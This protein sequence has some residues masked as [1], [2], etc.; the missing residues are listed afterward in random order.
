MGTSNLQFPLA[1]V[2]ATR[3]S[4][5]VVKGCPKHADSADWPDRLAPQISLLRA[6]DHKKRH[7][8]RQFLTVNI[9]RITS[10]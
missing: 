8:S 2:Q 7:N 1:I 9:W 4:C 3:I 5:S 10:C 6:A